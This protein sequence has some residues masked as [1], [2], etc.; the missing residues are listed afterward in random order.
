MGTIGVARIDSLPHDTPI[1]LIDRKK[2]GFLQPEVASYRVPEKS[3]YTNEMWAILGGE[4]RELWTV[5]P[6]EPVT[7][8]RI[9]DKSLE[10]K[11]I[12]AKEALSRGLT[13]VKLVD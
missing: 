9:E 5:H 11:F 7:P 13:H 6:G 12:S 8:S 1:K 2:T 10:N 3:K 4:P